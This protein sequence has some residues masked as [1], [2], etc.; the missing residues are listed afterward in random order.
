MNNLKPQTCQTIVSSDLLNGSQCMTID[1]DLNVIYLVNKYRQLV[2]IDVN[3]ES[4]KKCCDLCTQTEDS[5]GVINVEFMSEERSVCI[6]LTTGDIIVFNTMTDSHQVM[7]CLSD[8]LQSVAFSLDQELIALITTNQSLILMNKLFDILSQRDLKSD[9]FGCNETVS[10]NWGSKATQFHGEGQRDTRN[11]QE[12]YKSFSDFD[13]KLS[14]ISWRSDGLYFVTTYFDTITNFRKLQI[15]SRDGILQYTSEDINGLEG[16]ISWKPSGALI[17]S[18]Q[19]L[20]NKHIIVFAEKNGLKHGEFELPFS[21]NT[22]EVQSILWSNDSQILLVMGLERISEKNS[23]QVLMFWR[24]Q[25][26]KW[27]RKQRHEFTDYTVVTLAFDS[28]D[29]NLLHVIFSNGRYVRYR[30]KWSMD[31]MDGMIALVDGNRLKL[32][33][34]EMAVIPPPFYTK[35]ID[36]K[37]QVFDICFSK[38][39]FGVVLIDS[40][41]YLFERNT[42]KPTIDANDLF[43]IT[44][45]NMTK[46]SNDE[47]NCIYCGKCDNITN[48]MNLTIDE[49][50]VL[51]GNQ[52][53]VLLCY[54]YRNDSQKLDQLLDIKSDI[55][56]M[57]CKEDFIGIMTIDGQLLKF[58]P[59]DKTLEQ[60]MDRNDRKV[61]FP[62]QCSRLEIIKVSDKFVSLCLLENSSLYLDNEILSQNNC[63]SFINYKNK[64]LLFTTTDHLL[65]CWPINDDIFKANSN[66]HK[67]KAR[68][69]E[70][71]AKI[72]AAARDAKVVLQM[73]R[74][75]TE[76]IYPRALLLD[77]VM[78]KLNLLEFDSAIDLLRKHR[79]NLNFIYDIN[80]KNFIENIELFIEK[81]GKRCVEWLNLFIT[82]LS[83]DE[84]FQTITQTNNK[85][86]KF[87][88]RNLN[89]HNKVDMICD[90]M[91]E[92]M[93]KLDNKLYFHSILLTYI[94]KS[95][96][97]TDKALEMIKSIEDTMIRD[98]AIKFLLYIININQLFD[99]ALGTYNSDIFLMI[100][101]K[102]QKDPK[103]YLALLDE[104][105]KIKC[106]EYKC[107]KIDMH[108]KR[109]NK[110]LIH[111]SKLDDHFE[112]CLELIKAHSL[113]KNAVNLFDKSCDEK[114]QKVWKL[115]ADY[116]FQKKYFEESAI[117]YKNGHDF[118]N[119][120]KAYQLS[121]NWSAAI[122]SALHCKQTVNIKTLAQNLAKHLVIGGKHLEASY[123]LEIYAE[124]ILETIKTLIDGHEW[125]HALR[126]MNGNNSEE[127]TEYYK[128]ELFKHFEVI[129]DLITK[130]YNLLV[131]HMNR[132]EVV[133]Q[134]QLEK[135]V[136]VNSYDNFDD[137]S[138]IYSE[139]SSFNESQ[140]SGQK[141]TSSS[142][143]TRKSRKNTKKRLEMKK[144]IHKEGSADEDI[145]LIYAINEIIKNVDQIQEEISYILRALYS[146]NSRDKANTIQSE[147]TALL[148]LIN[149]IT[150][151]I[152]TQ[153]DNNDNQNE[154]SIQ[155]HKITDPLLMKSPELRKVDWKLVLL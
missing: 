7:G 19:M 149:S 60:W 4:V 9:E 17:A 62:H 106:F 50:G 44:L 6:A 69:V 38:N 92:T 11:K 136:D 22:F 27:D 128:S 153:N 57:K 98:K 63:N 93:N 52:S 29:A 23:T 89:N 110:A 5:F 71:G 36:F 121:G 25:N 91:R 72:I 42:T 111:I 80:P 139:T 117:A 24:Q 46:Q 45:E 104:L 101:S 30:W 78:S 77:I 134:Q 116:L 26:Y 115:Y 129:S 94:K 58:E 118:S 145:Q 79:I 151:E 155:K 114:K 142:L 49:T 40:T 16:L 148:D 70:R 39:V 14:R 103:E 84:N 3:T 67:I 74:G 47:L 124:D 133:R 141:S 37:S 32:S 61:V 34:F 66:Y 83:N 152:W 131:K 33:D 113:Y 54:D 90:L 35:S 100:A 120:V 99:E 65:H 31:E 12:N 147:F 88:S 20:P 8:G 10:V 119:A 96:P 55:L 150:K 135:T 143:A 18:S 108:L 64:F 140:T 95:V 13:D 105:N 154:E 138:D 51:Y 1:T 59:K 56:A 125:Q 41:V 97:E 127:L 144:Y 75:N 112:E 68:T 43:A 2:S 130:N 137:K 85:N 81:V 102:S 146:F 82:E 87:N 21:A 123:L 107:F 122:D 28:I 53:T 132:L 76:A 48:L 86:S 15:W 73:P 126:V 109:Y